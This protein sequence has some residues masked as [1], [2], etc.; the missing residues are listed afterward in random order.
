MSTVNE[1]STRKAVNTALGGTG[2]TVNERAFDKSVAAALVD[3]NVKTKPEV[4]ALTAEATANAT[5]EATAVTLVNSLKGKYNSL[6]AALK[7]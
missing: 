3:I 1:R 7:A 5:N 4:V 2:S 6:L